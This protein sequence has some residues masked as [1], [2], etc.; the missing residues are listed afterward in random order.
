MNIIFAVPHFCQKQ[1][2]GSGNTQLM[3]KA[4]QRSSQVE[5]RVIKCLG[6]VVIIATLILWI[7]IFIFVS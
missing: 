4:A 1:L 6:I 2:W 5:Q 3:M 7:R